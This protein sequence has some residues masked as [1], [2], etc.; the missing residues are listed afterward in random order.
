MDETATTLD[1][2]LTPEMV[3]IIRQRVETGSFAS[4]SDLMREA[5]R[6]WLKGE[7]EYEE[8]LAAV[9]ARVRQSLGDPRPSVPL[10]EAFDRI[11]RLYLERRKARGE[12]A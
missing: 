8:R 9:R 1:I 12:A 2:E 11:E 3:R 7:M 10:D 4:P 5:F 6:T